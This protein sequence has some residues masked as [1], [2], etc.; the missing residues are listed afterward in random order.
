MGLTIEERTRKVW[1][2]RY[3]ASKKYGVVFTDPPPDQWCE[4]IL[5][6]EQ[7]NKK[8]NDEMLNLASQRLHEETEKANKAKEEK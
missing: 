5:E 2:A 1:M 4:R 6:I 7:I 8:A 3:D